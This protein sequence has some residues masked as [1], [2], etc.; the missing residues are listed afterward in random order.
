VVDVLRQISQK[1]RQKVTEITLDMAANMALIA[2]K[3]FPQ[4]TQVTDRFHVQQLVLET[5]QDVRIQYRWQALEGAKLGQNMYEPEV[6]ANGD[7]LRQLLARS[8]YL[9][10]KKPTDW[11]PSQQERADLLFDRYPNL[12]KAYELN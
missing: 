1:A 11:T 9:L 8:R 2:K 10:Y 4:A 7:T 3:C 12:K 6:R 5:V